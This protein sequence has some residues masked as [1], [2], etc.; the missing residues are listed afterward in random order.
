[1]HGSIGP[2]CA[3]GR[4]QDNVLTVWTHSQGVY[5]LR[6]ALAELTKL[7]PENV[8][9]I[10][11]E[12][13]GCYGHN[14]ADDAGA[15]AALLAM[16]LPGVGARAVMREDEHAWSPMARWC[17]RARV[18]G[19]GE[20]SDWHTTSEQPAQRASGPAGSCSRLVPGGAVREAPA[21]A[22]A[23]ADRGRRSQRD[24]TLP[25]RPD[26]RRIISFRH[27]GALRASRARRVSQRLAIESF[28]D[29][30]ACR[31]GRIPSSSACATGGSRAR[32]DRAAAERL[33]RAG[34][35][36]QQARAR[37]A[38]P[39]KN[40]AARFAIACEVEVD[41]GA[42]A[43]RARGGAIDGEAVNPTASEPDRRRILQAL[44]WT[45]TGGDVQ[46]DP[47]T[48]LDWSTYPI[49]RFQNPPDSVEVH[50][51]NWPGQPYLGTAKQQGPTA[52]ARQRYHAT[53]ARVRDCR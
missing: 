31:P 18:R 27:A 11:L 51:I 24:T 43:P 36:A 1:M 14:G 15:D 3:V 5:P 47:I 46:P 35:S 12:G 9:C 6:A 23:A 13:S 10:H 29:E 37:L 49:L 4:Y 7:P 28:M 39:H 33:G 42:L 25:L 19:N 32:R 2:S 44:S 45:R 20:I 53:G 22:G 48:S 50:V 26:A 41:A 38:S 52:A 16:A 40:L 34:I 30:L 21:P 17:R 8:R